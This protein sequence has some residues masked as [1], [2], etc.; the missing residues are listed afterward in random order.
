MKDLE[1]LVQYLDGE[2]NEVE[3]K[4][5]VEK[6]K[7]DPSLSE[8][9]DL[10]KDV[11][12]L[13]GDKHLENFEESLKEIETLYFKNKD[14]ES[15]ARTSKKLE[16][17]RAAAIFI[18][19]VAAGAYFVFQINNDSLTT[20]ELFTAYYEKMPADF[21]TRSEE[22]VNDDF[23]IAIKLYNE[24]KYQQAIVEFNK[25]LEKD[26]SNTAARLFLGI[27][28]TET[29]QFDS[30]S[31]HFKNIIEKHDPIFEEHAS[32]YLALCYI[33]TNKP[34]SAK[35]LLNKLVNTRSFYIKKATDL[36]SEL[37]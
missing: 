33:K 23:I 4:Q 6:L 30:A 21:T 2:L 15:S 17:L 36:L 26:P 27:C 5:L 8:K 32:W 29:K 18:V 35:Q 12:Q 24:N 20:D 3:K 31:G 37:R 13:I 11:D 19:L 28:Y 34:D 25:I 14:K 16:W 22:M 9:L 10:I 7:N 1:Q